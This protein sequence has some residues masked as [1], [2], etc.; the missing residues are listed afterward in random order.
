MSCF[1]RDAGPHAGPIGEVR[2]V[3][4]KKKA[5]EE[6]ARLTLEYLERVRQVRWEFGKK[7]MEGIKGGET[8]GLG[9]GRSVEGEDQAKNV[10][11]DE[12]ED[13]ED[14]EVFEDAVDG[15]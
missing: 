13:E 6:C 5:K 15:L 11:K 4:G 10:V 3:Y 1:F 8:M 9:V 7:M 12:D 14:D 2:N